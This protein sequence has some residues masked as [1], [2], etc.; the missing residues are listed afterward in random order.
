MELGGAWP[1]APGN[2]KVITLS[3]GPIRMLARQQRNLIP[4][5][6]CAWLGTQDVTIPQRVFSIH[7]PG[8]LVSQETSPKLSGVMEVT[9]SHDK[10][11]W[12]SWTAPQRP[13]ASQEP[14]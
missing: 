1:D 3:Y 13:R 5:K 9:G 10:K 11:R 12:H 2:T 7:P 14:G 8:R 4:G 6:D